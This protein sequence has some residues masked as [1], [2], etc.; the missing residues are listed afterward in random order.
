MKTNDQNLVV[1][2]K[3]VNQTYFTEKLKI[4]AIYW[5]PISK[6][7]NGNPKSPFWA[8]CITDSRKIILLDKLKTRAPKYV[9]EYLI[10]H[11]CLHFL[12]GNHCKSFNKAEKLFV[13]FKKADAWLARHESMLKAGR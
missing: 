12:W 1:L 9:L 2:L 8:G 10:Y 13:H 7:Y 4:K 3:K 11:E 5:R 6:Q